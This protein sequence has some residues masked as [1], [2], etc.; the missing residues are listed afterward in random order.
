MKLCEQRGQAREARTRRPRS[1]EQMGACRQVA[2]ER[3]STAW[4]TQGAPGAQQPSSL[5]VPLPGPCSLDSPAP[6]GLEDM[7]WAVLTVCFS[8]CNCL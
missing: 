6:W 7:L 4:L 2:P 1:H 3:S 8:L 5:G